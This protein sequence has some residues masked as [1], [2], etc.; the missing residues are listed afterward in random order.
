MSSWQPGRGKSWRPNATLSAPAADRVFH[1]QNR[2]GTTPSGVLSTL[3]LAAL[4]E[5]GNYRP[6]FLPLLKAAGL[7]Q[8]L[9]LNTTTFDPTT[10]ADA[11]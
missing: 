8:Q 4:D 1:A 7:V 3:A 11:A 5:N 6:G 10:H 9:A 2:M